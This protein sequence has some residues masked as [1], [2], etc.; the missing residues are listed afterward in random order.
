MNT[1]PPAAAETAESAPTPILVL[2]SPRHLHTLADPSG[3]YTVWYAATYTQTAPAPSAAS[4]GTLADH[5]AAAHTGGGGGGSGEGVD[6]TAAFST[7][8]FAEYNARVD[9]QMEARRAA[10]RYDSDEERDP[11]PV[12]PPPPQV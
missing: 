9:A 12:P 3:G 8:R 10:D 4:R 5:L 6:P 11:R 2:S 7:R 1:S